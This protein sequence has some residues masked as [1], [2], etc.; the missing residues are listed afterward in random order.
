MRLSTACAE[1]TLQAME[2][3][4]D[5]ANVKRSHVL[6]FSQALSDFLIFSEVWQGLERW[7]TDSAHWA[8]M[9]RDDSEF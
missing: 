7:Q 6:R 5:S 1:M 3:S 9:R 8:L 4:S 2:G